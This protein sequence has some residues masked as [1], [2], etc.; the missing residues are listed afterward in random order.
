MLPLV[1][2]PARVKNMFEITMIV[3]A[4][5]DG[6]AVDNMESCTALAVIAP[7]EEAE[8]RLDR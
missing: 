7:D 6:E 5:V 1:I 4:A 2:V 8:C 3:G